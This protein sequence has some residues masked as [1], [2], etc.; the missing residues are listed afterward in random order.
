MAIGGEGNRA[1]KATRIFHCVGHVVRAFFLTVDGV[2]HSVECLV[3]RI[4]YS[5]VKRFLLIII[6]H[7]VLLWGV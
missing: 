1:A 3:K 5:L 6:V 2:L 4:L 7:S